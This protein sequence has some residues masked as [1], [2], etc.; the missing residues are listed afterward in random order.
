MFDK[1]SERICQYKDTREAKKVL[2][3]LTDF[4]LRDIGIHRGQI[5]KVAQG[6]LDIHRA[7]RDNK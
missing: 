5:D 2:N 6:D 1:I 4:E 3:L 7:V